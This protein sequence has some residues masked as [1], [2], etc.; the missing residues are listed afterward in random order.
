VVVSGMTATLTG[1]LLGDWLRSRYSGSYFLVAAGG[2]FVGFPAFL[3][4]LY[5]PFPWAWGFI[6]LACFCL[7]LN[8]G[9][10]NTP[11]ANGTHPSIR[12][13]AFAVNISIIHALGDAI[14]PPIIGAITDAA[15][16]NMNVG[17]LAV[18]AMIL[19]SGVLWLLAA[20]YLERDTALAPT[21][22]D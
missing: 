11:L 5:V 7:F 8:T 17:F 9:P 14:S 4:V 21:R 12:A 20:R 16:N 6:F 10:T 22:F 1:G 13:T 2:M 19:V 15:N 3:A 18:S